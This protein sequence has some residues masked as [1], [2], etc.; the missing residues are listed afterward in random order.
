MTSLNLSYQQI[1]VRNIRMLAEHNA[2]DLEANDQ[3]LLIQRS[4]TSYVHQF[5]YRF[6]IG[7]T[8]TDK[9]T[10]AVIKKLVDSIDG[11]ITIAV[12]GNQSS[13]LSHIKLDG[14]YDNGNDVYLSHNQIKSFFNHIA[15]S[16]T[17]NPF[18]QNKNLLRVET[19]NFLDPKLAELRL[20]KAQGKKVDPDHKLHRRIQKARLAAELLGIVPEA[21]E[22][23]ATGT[24]IVKGLYNNKLRAKPLSEEQIRSGKSLGVFKRADSNVPLLVKIKNFFK[25][26]SPTAQ[27]YYLPKGDLAK[28]KATV[29]AYILDKHL[30]FNITPPSEMIR[31][32]GEDG[33]FELF[34]G[35]RVEAKK[36]FRLGFNNKEAYELNEK[37][38]FQFMALHNYLTGDLDRHRKNWFLTPNDYTLEKV[39]EHNAA[40]KEYKKTGNMFCPAV[41]IDRLGFTGLDGI[42]NANSFPVCH[43][44]YTFLL[45][46][47]YQWRH[48]EIAKYAF[49]PEVVEFVNNISIEKFTLCVNE[50]QKNIPDFFEKD[51]GTALYQ[52]FAV[53]KSVVSAEKSTPAELGEIRTG[54]KIRSVLREEEYISNFTLNVLEANQNQK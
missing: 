41:D 2:S 8:D 13:T 26:Q 39:K 24:L 27:N 40:K 53:L 54:Q 47:Q 34:L 11:H 1:E 9:K 51:M 17:V 46:N 15:Q 37:I 20:E 14:Y 30:G 21:N 44:E 52:R 16:K 6:G 32:M 42:D 7:S 25:R 35:G 31:F 38:L 36:V 22:E 28:P 50:I 33:A 5:C 49:T 12:M 43:P 3:G 4:Q 19:Q 29:A 45:K 18:L 48:L 23:G 10:A